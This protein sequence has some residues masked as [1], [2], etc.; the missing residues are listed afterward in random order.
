[1]WG[2]IIRSHKRSTFVSD[3]PLLQDV[4]QCMN[5]GDM[6]VALHMLRQGAPVDTLVRC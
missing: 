6:T 4:R 5:C 3:G 1:M 2:A